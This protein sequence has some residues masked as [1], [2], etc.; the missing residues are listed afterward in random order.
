M[1]TLTVAVISVVIVV[2]AGRRRLTRRRAASPRLVRKAAFLARAGSSYGYAASAAGHIDSWR[3]R[4]LPVLV[5]PA[6][7]QRCADGEQGIVYLDHAGAALPLASQLRAVAEDCT[8]RPLGNPHSAGPAA[9]AASAELDRARSLVLA[10]FCG[11]HAPD[12]E[13]IWTA[14]A[15]ASL[16]LVAEHFQ[17]CG[18]SALLM[19]SACHTSVLG[20]R[21]PAS[22]RGA[23]C[24]C[25]DR[26]GDLLRLA[27][28]ATEAAEAEAAEAEVEPAAGSEAA[29]GA[30]AEAEA[31]AVHH[32]AVLPVECNLTGDV[33]DIRAASAGLAQ[34]GTGRGGVWC[35]DACWTPQ[36][37]L[38]PTRGPDPRPRHVV[39]HAGRRK[40]GGDGSAPPAR[41]RSGPLR[42]L[43][44]QAV[45]LSDGAGHASRPLLAPSCPNHPLSLFCLP[46]LP[47]SP[48]PLPPPAPA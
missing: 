31:R 32:L 48:P 15:T 46:P 24:R 16:R 6:E 2:V 40:G 3:S 38:A 47:P 7:A 14:G 44:L 45:R 35:V 22:G 28:Q 42:R 17:F 34:L 5:R 19:P 18:R 26:P 1:Q 4:E 9:G 43:L 10:H 23:T 25:A 11:S 37:Q 30:G 33:S 36:Q 12:W 41:Q 29:A 21:G 13:V 39:A 20:M 27:A 8:T